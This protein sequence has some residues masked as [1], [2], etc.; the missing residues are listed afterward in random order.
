MLNGHIYPEF[1]SRTLFRSQCGL[2]LELF[3][4]DL[5]SAVAAKAQT[6]RH[7]ERRG[8]HLLIAPEGGPFALAMAGRPS[9]QLCV[10]VECCGRHGRR[11]RW[12]ET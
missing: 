11:R 8:P 5:R 7:R 3:L 2:L 4:Q 10:D 12:A 9:V 1:S 6:G